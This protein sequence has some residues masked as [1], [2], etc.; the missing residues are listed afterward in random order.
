M[1]DGQAI[2]NHSFN[3]NPEAHVLAAFYAYGLQFNIGANV[4]VGD[5][6]H[7]GF[8]D[9]VTGPTAGNPQVKV[10]DGQAIA[11]HTFNN[12]NPDASLL[13][14]LFAFG[15]QFNVGAF[16]AVGDVNGDSFGDVIAGAT[17]GNPQVKVYSGQAIAQH[18]FDGGN[19]DASLLANFYAYQLGQNIGVSV[20]AANFDVNGPAEI[21]TGAA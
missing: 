2:A 12:G 7:D 18:T 17:V 21:L 6:T 14:S 10:Y 13:A 4:A 15:L 11:N 8:A 1:F 20:G 16:V 19:P 9:I 5:V 3:G